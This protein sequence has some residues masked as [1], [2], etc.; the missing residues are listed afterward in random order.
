MIR[1][2]ESCDDMTQL[3]ATARAYQDMHSA[4]GVIVSGR[5]N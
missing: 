5:P 1:I 2:G 3:P 4:S